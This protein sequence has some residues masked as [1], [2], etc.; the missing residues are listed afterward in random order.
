MTWELCGSDIVQGDPNKQNRTHKY[1]HES[2]KG[3]S[4]FFKFCQFKLQS[5]D[6]LST[7]FY[8]P[9]SVCIV[10]MFFS[11]CAPNVVLSI[12][13]TLAH[14]AQNCQR[15]SHIPP[16]GFAW[17]FLRLLPSVHLLFE[18]CSHSHCPWDTPTYKNLGGVQVWWM[19]CPLHITP[20]ADQSVIKS[21]SKPG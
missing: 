8:P 17:S 20:P 12:E 11:K 3:P 5:M 14:V 7:K 6:D 16:L 13:G 2:Y 1:V 21:L 10:F 9:G 4:N 18:D 15:L 19:R